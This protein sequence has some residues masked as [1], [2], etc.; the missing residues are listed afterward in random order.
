[1][2]RSIFYAF[3]FFLSCFTNAQGTV[4]GSQNISGQYLFDHSSR[5][6]LLTHSGK[7]RFQV[8]SS[9]YH[10][11]VDLQEAFIVVFN[12]DKTDTIFYLHS[13]G[14]EQDGVVYR[15][16]FQKY[17]PDLHV[18]RMGAWMT[19]IHIENIVFSHGQNNLRGLGELSLFCYP[20]GIFFVLDCICNAQEWIVRDEGKYLY[21]ARPGFRNCEGLSPGKMSF[22]LGFS[23]SISFPNVEPATAPIFAEQ[24][25]LVVCP[26]VPEQKSLLSAE[27]HQVIVE[28]TVDSQWEANDI[29]EVGAAI[30]FG[31]DRDDLHALSSSIV[32]PLSANNFIFDEHYGAFLSYFRRAGTY[33]IRGR[34][35]PTPHPAPGYVGGSR[36]TIHND[37]LNRRIYVDQVDNWGGIA[38]GIV[39]D[40]QN[41][42]LPKHVQFYLNYPEKSSLGERPGAHMILPLEM[43]SG[44]SKTLRIHTLFNQLT[45]RDLIYL[46]S[47]EPDSH[48]SPGIFQVSVNRH[49]TH[50]TRQDPF[51]ITDFRPHP[52]DVK[53]SSASASATSFLRY[54]NESDTEI[55]LRSGFYEMIETGPGLIEYKLLLESQDGKVHGNAHIFQYANSD[56]TRIFCDVALQFEEDVHLSETAEIPINFMRFDVGNPMVFRNFAYKAVEGNTHVG[57]LT[58]AGPGTVHTY[59]GAMHNPFFFSM[60]KATNYGGEPDLTISDRSGNPAMIVTKWEATINGENVLPAAYAFASGAVNNYHRTLAVIPSK[61]LTYIQKGSTIRFKMMLI[62]GG[63]GTTDERFAEKEFESW[64]NLSV[65]AR[66]GMVESTHPIQIR[67]SENVVDFDVSG[68]CN[69]VAVKINGL[70]SL[71]GF[72]AYVLTDSGYEKT[73]GGNQS[74]AWY[75]TWQSEDGSYG[76]TFLVDIPEGDE[77]VRVRASSLQ[78]GDDFFDMDLPEEPQNN[79]YFLLY[80]NPARKWVQIEH[81]VPF[82]LYVYDVR[83][84]LVKSL[85]LPGNVRL[86]LSLPSGLYFFQLVSDKVGVVDVKKVYLMQ[87]Q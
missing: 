36:L 72:W 50:S 47:L 48:K 19:E 25:A 33:R 61:N 41:F 60:F 82:G 43:P 3:W 62:T 23:S 22:S 8:K 87:D 38:G 28:H 53:G 15:A 79:G 78:P 74:D 34:G 30:L 76:V 37:N 40:N 80:P 69:R 11:V 84:V 42:P 27:G 10:L 66:T 26:T 77:V 86:P 39:T 2:T 13:F 51:N 67:A 75:N 7:D 70:S 81:D 17:K 73:Y 5:Q 85:Q 21:P 20:D 9:F 35:T 49:E 12:S 83:G 29:H 54:V 24:T 32:N 56:H 59:G 45:H 14:V 46:N 68:G 58:N 18:L 57:N 52:N 64:N 65:Y 63:D 4:T 16:D 31:E 71:H 55:M 1:M 44:F 6:P